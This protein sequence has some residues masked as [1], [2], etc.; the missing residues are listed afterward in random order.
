MNELISFQKSKVIILMLKYFTRI[1]DIE[2]LSEENEKLKKDIE[3]LRDRLDALERLL[4]IPQGS[5]IT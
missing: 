3:G 2:K 4:L 5:T 1:S